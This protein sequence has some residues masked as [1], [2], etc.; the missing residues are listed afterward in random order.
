MATIK[1]IAS[2]SDYKK[3]MNKIDALMA[4]GSKNVTRAELAEIRSLAQEAQKYE[5][6]KFVIDPPTTLAGIIE[7]KMYE[8]KLKQKE[9]AAKLHVSTAKLSLILAGKQRPDVDF[10][11][12]VHQ[13][14]GVDAGF[15]L[16]VV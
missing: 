6:S 12:A 15:L 7:M 13:Q 11:K 14:L 9:L 2:A 1:K 4:K 16:S 8:R 3:V 5:Q 10:L